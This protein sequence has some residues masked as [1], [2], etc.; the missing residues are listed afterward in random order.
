MFFLYPV[1]QRVSQMASVFLQSHLPS[2][3]ISVQN[4]TNVMSQF[5]C[6]I[7]VITCR[8]YS[9]FNFMTFCLNV[10]EHRHSLPYMYYRITDIVSLCLY[11]LLLVYIVC[12]CHVCRMFFM[13]P[14]SQRVSK[15]ASVFL[16][17]ISLYV[18]T[19]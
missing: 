1:S 15:M 8:I 12:C 17:C 13:Y 2:E 5:T 9:M 11:F 7:I 19:P 10:S 3:I 16:Q 18:L 4:L 6:E 14:V